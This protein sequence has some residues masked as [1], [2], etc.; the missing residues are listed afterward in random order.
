MPDP[1]TMMSK[2]SR[3]IKEHQD[4]TADAADLTDG[5]LIKQQMAVGK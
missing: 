3:C 1:T 5:P 4:I 2:T